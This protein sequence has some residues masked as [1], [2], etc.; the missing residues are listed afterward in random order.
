MSYSHGRLSQTK[1]ILA[2][3][4]DS[5]WTVS[6]RRRRLLRMKPVVSP[7]SCKR[8]YNEAHVWAKR[9][10]VG[11]LSPFGG[12]KYILVFLT[13]PCLHNVVQNNQ[14]D[15]IV[16]NSL[17]RSLLQSHG[18][19]LP[20]ILA[21]VLEL[22][23]RPDRLSSGL[24]HGFCKKNKFRLVL[25]QIVAD[26]YVIPNGFRQNYIVLLQV[27]TSGQM[28]ASMRKRVMFNG[29]FRGTLLCRIA[30]SWNHYWAGW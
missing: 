6:C 20:P 7:C 28:A 5:E 30:L 22:V 3:S 29:F 27:P 15:P 14:R 25:V 18:C 8:C 12:S 10:T 17:K 13:R 11:S 4:V 24:D 1:H 16:I 2:R 9:L 19:K 26:Q 21:E 23:C